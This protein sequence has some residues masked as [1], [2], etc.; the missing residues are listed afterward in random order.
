MPVYYIAGIYILDNALMS[1][2]EACLRSYRPQAIG[3]GILIAEVVKVALAF[4][5]ILGLGQLFL[6]AVISLTVSILVQVLYYVKVF[7]C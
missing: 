7:S 1:N 6:G 5:I 3:Y 4:G 2:L